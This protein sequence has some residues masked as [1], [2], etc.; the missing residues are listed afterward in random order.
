MRKRYAVSDGRLM[1]SQRG[2]RPDGDRRYRAP[3]KSEGPVADGVVGVNCAENS[4]LRSNDNSWPE[5][6]E[7]R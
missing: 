4:A 5:L 1:R 6:D 3:L 7:P 2:L